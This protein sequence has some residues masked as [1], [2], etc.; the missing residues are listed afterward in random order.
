MRVLV[1]VRA[2]EG[3]RQLI[4]LEALLDACN[5]WDGQFD[6]RPEAAR[7]SGPGYKSVECRALTFG[8]H[9]FLHD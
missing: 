3:S 9:G 4:G 7:D 1:E 8:F 2:D 5:S 6:K